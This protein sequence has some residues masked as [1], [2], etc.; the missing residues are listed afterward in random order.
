VA[1]LA[2]SIDGADL[3]GVSM[4][5]GV[6]FRVTRATG[7]NGA[8]IPGAVSASAVR[9]TV[10]DQSGA[11]TLLRAW[12]QEVV[13]GTGTPRDVAV[14]AYDAQLMLLFEWTLPGSLPVSGVDPFAANG[15]VGMTFLAGG[16]GFRL[17]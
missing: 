16:V 12:V 9:I 5:A 14:R 1:V 8:L 13:G 11:E 17:P 3:P 7:S 4:I 2:L 10:L 6:G 15:T